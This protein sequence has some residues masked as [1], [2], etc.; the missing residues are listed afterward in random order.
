MSA[1]LL[2]PAMLLDAVLG[3]PKAIWSR[4]PHPAVLMGRV[5]GWADETFIVGGCCFWYLRYVR[6]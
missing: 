4:L 2:L 5:V 1:V 3:E 6:C